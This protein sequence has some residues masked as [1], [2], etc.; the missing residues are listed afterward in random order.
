MAK[1]QTVCMAHVDDQ[2]AFFIDNHAIGAFT[3]LSKK[4]SERHPVK[5]GIVILL[6]CCLGCGY[7]S[8]ER[9]ASWQA[10][11][12]DASADPGAI[13]T[14]TDW[15]PIALPSMFLLPYPPARTFRYLWL[16]GAANIAGDPSQYAGIR[17]GRIYYIDRTY[18]NGILV[19]SQ[20]TEEYNAVHNP[21]AYA[22]P[23]GVLKAGKNEVLIRLGIYGTEYGG[24]LDEVLLLGARDF[25]GARI[26]DEFIYRQLPIG[27]ALFLLGQMAFNMIFFL[28]RKKQRANLY[29]AAMCLIWSLY[30]FALFSPYFPFTDDFRITFLWSCTS[31]VPILFLMLIQS[32]YKVYLSYFNRVVIPLLLAV[33][34]IVLAFQDTT[35]A[36]YPGPILGTGTLFAVIPLL[37]YVMYRVNSRRPDPM[38]FVFIGFGLLPG[39]FIGWDIVNYLWVHHYPPLTHTYTIP[40]FIVGV[41]ILIIRE[42][43]KKEIELDLLY[44]KLEEPSSEEPVKKPGITSSTE[45]KLEKIIEFLK[46]N[47]A[48]DIS[49][50]GLAGAMNLSPDHMSRMFKAYTGKKINDYINELRIT[51]AAGR[52]ADP[53]VKIIDIAFAVGFESLATFNRS[54]LKVTGKTPT[55]FRAALKKDD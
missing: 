10:L 28:W 53:E 38:I 48:S 44:R 25:I 24:L 1:S 40:V 31:F 46:E 3:H 11:F 33:T 7:S 14:R 43:I 39:L 52:L 29:A 30:I 8:A 47:Y 16:K 12:D 49:R 26:S 9:V 18:V 51:D 42:F 34:G 55:D 32:F 22:I 20:L 45:G 50:E 4:Q 54:F 37:S 5:I 36:F 17:L 41:M 2:S 35:A 19:G 21:R 13:A 15:T 27:I 6:L 23:K